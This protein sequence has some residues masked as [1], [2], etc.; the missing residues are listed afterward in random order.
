[1]QPTISHIES[2]NV[3]LHHAGNEPSEMTYFLHGVSRTVFRNEGETPESF[4]V[5]VLGVIQ[6]DRKAIKNSR[7]LLDPDSVVTVYAGRIEG[8]DLLR[9]QFM[10]E[11]LI[12]GL[13]REASAPPSLNGTG[14]SRGK[15]L[16]ILAR[17]EGIIKPRKTRVRATKEASGH[18]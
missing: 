17:M 15:A 3:T 2:H 16:G 8:L 13:Q 5:R 11:W 12:A 7:S 1:M 6:Q 9:Q 14:A 10:R 4:W 18:R